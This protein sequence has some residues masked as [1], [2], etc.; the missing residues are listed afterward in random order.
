MLDNLPYRLCHDN[1]GPE[2]EQGQ[3]Q[4]QQEQPQPLQQHQQQEQQAEND[5]DDAMDDAPIPPQAAFQQVQHLIVEHMLHIVDNLQQQAAALAAHPQ[6]QQQAG[7]AFAQHVDM[8]LMAHHQLIANQAPGAAE[9]EAAVENIEA[10]A[11]QLAE[12]AAPVP[13]G[14]DPEDLLEAALDAIQQQQQVQQQQQQPEVPYP[15]IIGLRQHQIEPH[16]HFL[17]TMTGLGKHLLSFFLMQVL[18]LRQVSCV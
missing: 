12:G 7:N 14:V 4:Q 9:V 17:D 16:L 8:M 13:P 10:V 1:A 11:A 5:A 15:G 6:Q 2:E 3:Q 18:V